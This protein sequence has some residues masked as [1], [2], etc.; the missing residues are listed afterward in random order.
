MAAW[1]ITA[2][3]ERMIDLAMEVDDAGRQTPAIKQQQ[4]PT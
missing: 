4:S 1:Q 3:I 2:R